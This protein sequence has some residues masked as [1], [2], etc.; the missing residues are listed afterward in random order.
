[1]RNHGTPQTDQ[2]I[3]NPSEVIESMQ[4]ADFSSAYALN[5]YI[6]DELLKK[7]SKHSHKL[8]LIYT[9]IKENIESANDFLNT[10]IYKDKSDLF[11]NRLFTSQPDALNDIFKVTTSEEYIKSVLKNLNRDQLSKTNSEGF[12]TRLLNYQAQ[13]IL[14]ADIFN[15]HD[16][17]RKLDVLNLEIT[18]LSPL[19]NR[20]LLDFIYKEK[21]YDINYKNIETI[22]N[23]YGNIDNSSNDLKNRNY[24][25]ILKSEAEYLKDYI[26][27][28][29]LI[30]LDRVYFSEENRLED[31]K[32]IIKLLNDTDLEIE[33]KQRVIDWNDTPLETNN[34]KEIP[35]E[36]WDYIFTEN[37]IAP[38]WKNISDYISQ[39]KYTEEPIIEYLTNNIES[40]TNTSIK[41]S[42][43][44]DNSRQELFWFLFNLTKLEDNT[45]KETI[46]VLPDHY[47][48]F[49]RDSSFEKQKI[50]IE[51]KK[52]RLNEESFN[53]TNDIKIKAIL[54]INNFSLYLES[55]NN[56]NNY[57]L[58]NDIIQLILESKL[59]IEEKIEIS[60]SINYSHELNEN[61]LKLLL[62]IA[63][64]KSFPLEIIP[65]HNFLELI[66]TN[67][68]SE[69]CI[70]TITKLIDIHDSDFIISLIK[71]LP[72]PICDI[73]YNGKKPSIPNTIA[74]KNLVE[75]LKKNSYISSFTEKKDKLK[76]YTFN[77]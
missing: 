52:V 47:Q 18:D 16:Q 10:Y 44:D 9:F 68:N 61:L 54:I 19:E 23:T 65:S 6:I 41:N 72:H 1:M 31:N 66:S 48:D 13:S 39:K 34:I 8:E 60:K 45:Y 29:V 11:V 71:K 26:Y 56:G 21:L 53:N 75:K 77:S 24:T 59:K 28:E 37:K 40:W 2:N 30:Y 62:P 17:I 50:L 57:E 3:D 73:A 4:D 49:P 70:S 14:N 76:I 35:E 7:P 5:I 58:D 67:R 74:N 22:I 43:I 33:T 36:L 12:L 42:I 20:D 15:N 46:K 27:E 38:N 32:T 55:K 63:N 69:L 64:D 25:T 51:S